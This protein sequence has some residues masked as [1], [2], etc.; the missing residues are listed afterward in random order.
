[1][2]Y[3][4]GES[5]GPFTGV[6]EP[7]RL[8][9]VK[10]AVEL[11][12]DIN[13]HADFGDYPMTGAP[14]YTLLYYPLNIDDLLDKGVGDPRWSGSTALIGAV[15][16]GQPSIVQFLVDHGAQCGREDQAGMDSADGRAGGVFRQCQK[17][18]SARGSDSEKSYGG[19]RFAGGEWTALGLRE[20][21]DRGLP[22]ANTAIVRRNGGI[23]PDAQMLG[24][25][26]SLDLG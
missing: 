5:P 22:Q 20:R 21:R 4:E 24:L 16:S 17:R 23:G 1:M 26:Q 2:D 8:D 6:T 10:L 15:V 7:E 14:D 19:A 11:G 3:W 9:A 12:N 25:Q 18:V 13:A